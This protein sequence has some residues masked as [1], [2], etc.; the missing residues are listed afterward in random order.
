MIYIEQSEKENWQFCQ[1]NSSLNMFFF[2]W[3]DLDKIN[4]TLLAHQ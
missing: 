3:I 1:K 4:I 2:I